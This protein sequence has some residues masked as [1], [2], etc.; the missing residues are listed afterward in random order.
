MV[1][2]GFFFF[3]SQ[4]QNAITEVVRVRRKFIRIDI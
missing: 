4:A 1:F 2:V 3:I